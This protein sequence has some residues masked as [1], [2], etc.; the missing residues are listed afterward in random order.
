MGR[1]NKSIR[2]KVETM[3]IIRDLE[4][5]MRANGYTVIDTTKKI[6]PSVKDDFPQLLIQ[7]GGLLINEIEFADIFIFTM[8]KDDG[9]QGHYDAL[10]GL[11][12][13]IQASEYV[14][15]LTESTEILEPF[16]V[17]RIGVESYA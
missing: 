14:L 10:K 9:M 5:Y 13:V 6:R 11:V 16:Y 7:P 2:Q 3:S 15:S 8:P 1:R 4:D 12:E 17:T